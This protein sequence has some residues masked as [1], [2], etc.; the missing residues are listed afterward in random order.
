MPTCDNCGAHV[1]P[2]YERVFAGQDGV[3]SGC[4]ACTARGATP[5]EGGR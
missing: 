1:T 3:L 2:A 5:T 4:P